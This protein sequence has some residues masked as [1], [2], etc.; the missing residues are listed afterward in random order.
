MK[1]ATV[2]RVRGTVTNEEGKPW[3]EAEIGL[4]SIPEA[5]PEPMELSQRMEGFSIFA[6]GLRRA[7]AGA[8]VSSA[9]ADKNGQ[10]E[11]PA[12]QSGNWRIINRPELDAPMRGLA[13]VFVGRSDVEDVQVHYT[14]PFNLTGTIE[15]KDENPGSPHANG[16]TFLINPDTNEFVRGGR[17]E[18]E[19]DGLWFDSILPG[20]YK[21]IF[22]PGLSGQVFLGEN[23]AI[24]QTLPVI[25]DGPQLRIV[26][27]ASAGTVRG[28]VEKGDGATVVLIPQ[29]IDGVALGQTIICGTGGSFELSEVSP[30]DY[31]IAAFD[32]MNGFSPSAAMLSRVPS[33]GISVKV[34]E[35]TAKDVTLSAIAAPR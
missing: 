27:K 21:V 17:V 12:V 26:L 16:E 22:K 23:E 7:L 4:Y 35:G 2:Y 29:R 6:I 34:E 32:H 24:G 18:S 20:R 11:F 1:T 25:A 19:S 5:T 13:D 28:T 9:T 15:R 33:R 8:A 10:F 30:G 14:T 3:P 31:Y